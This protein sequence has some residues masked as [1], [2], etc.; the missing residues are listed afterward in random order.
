MASWMAWHNCDFFRQIG[1]RACRF[2]FLPRYLAKAHECYFIKL[3]TALPPAAEPLWLN[4]S[5][6]WTDLRHSFAQV[7]HAVGYRRDA[8]L[9]DD[10]ASAKASGVV[11]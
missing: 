10:S 11:L 6:H 2:H 9:R 1:N 5:R 3:E 8:D 7:S 4:S